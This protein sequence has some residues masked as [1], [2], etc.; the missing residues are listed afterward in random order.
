MQKIEAKQKAKIDGAVLE[1]A[2]NNKQRF[3]AF[4]IA[5]TNNLKPDIVRKRLFQLRSDDKL[6]V[7]YELMCPICSSITRTSH[8][9]KQI[10]YKEILECKEC[11]EEF[12]VEPKDIFVTFTPNKE[13]YDEECK[14]V[15]K[16]KI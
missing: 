6:D 1:L 13:Y 9:E 14:G 10:P 4:Y 12:E 7:N 16:K 11:N 15:V 5:S 8:K 2:C 3:T